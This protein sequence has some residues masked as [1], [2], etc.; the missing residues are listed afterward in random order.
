MVPNG[1][2]EADVS[3]FVEELMAKRK[4]AEER[5]K[6][7]DSLHELANRTLRDAQ[8]MAEDLK[9][10]GWQAEENAR[11]I[12]AEANERVEKIVEA[13][14]QGARAPKEGAQKDSERK[15]ASITSSAQKEAFHC[16]RRIRRLDG[17]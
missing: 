1:L 5:L 16:C 3:A 13:A 17:Y 11:A 9:E 4:E 2:A 12:I 8:Q 14:D 6:H 10:E 15:A 7:I